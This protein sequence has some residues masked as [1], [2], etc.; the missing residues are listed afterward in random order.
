MRPNKYPFIDFKSYAKAENK[1]DALRSIYESCKTFVSSSITYTL[2]ISEFGFSFRL[3]EIKC[4]VSYNLSPKAI[5]GYIKRGK[6]VIRHSSPSQYSLMETAHKLVKRCCNRFIADYEMLYNPMTI[7]FE[8]D[9]SDEDLLDYVDMHYKRPDMTGSDNLLIKFEG[10][11][12]DVKPFVTLLETGTEYLLT[13]ISPIAR[14]VRQAHPNA[15]LNN[16][17]AAA[18]ADM[19]IKQL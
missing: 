2:H 10:L 8:I 6:Y 9:A 16:I 13:R 12:K 19:Y 7:Y 1:E 15:T 14:G 4:D 3:N 11:A 17:R 18:I 5:I